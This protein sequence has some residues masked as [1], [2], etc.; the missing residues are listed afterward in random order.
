MRCCSH[1]VVAAFLAAM[2]V[3]PAAGQSYRQ[4]KIKTKAE[5]EPL[6]FSRIITS[7]TIINPNLRNTIN[8]W[9]SK[10][11]GVEIVTYCN[12]FGENY[13]SCSGELYD[14]TAGKENY[15]LWIRL[16]L[17]YRNQYELELE[18]YEITTFG[19]RHPVMHLSTTDDKFNRTW[20]WRVMHDEETIELQREI[21]KDYFNLIADSLQRFLRYGPDYES[22][23]L[24]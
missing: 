15:D 24:Y 10:K 17:H 6:T 2:C 11:N 22:E 7:G 12:T 8:G 4:N 5:P 3:I 9:N 16:K 14:L 23:L 13:L 21:A 20:L 1:I 18:A 19:D